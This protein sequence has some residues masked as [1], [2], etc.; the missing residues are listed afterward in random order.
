MGDLPT[1]HQHQA[2]TKKQ[3]AKRRKSV[4]DANDFMVGGENVL[5]PKTGFLVVG[6]VD[7]R[8]WNRVSACLHVRVVVDF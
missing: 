8:M 6:F 1:H 7:L 5:A 4:L 3:K 2:K